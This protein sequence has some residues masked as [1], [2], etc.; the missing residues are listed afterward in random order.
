MIRIALSVSLLVTAVSTA[1]ADVSLTLP[2]KKLALSVAVQT[3]G[4]ATGLA[5]DLAVGVTDKL[6]VAIVHST[7]NATG[8]WSGSGTGSL[9]ITGD[10]CGDLYTGGALLAKLG[11][12]STPSFAFAAL[13]GVIHNI[14]AERSG[15]G[16][17]FEALYLAG[18]V[19]VHFKP[20]IYIGLDDRDAMA[21]NREYINAP[22]SLL[23][24]ATKTLQLGVQ[25]GVAGPAEGFGDAYRIPVGAMGNYAFGA[26]MSA[27]LAFNLDRVAGGGE[28]A[29]AT[30][31]R[32][33]TLTVG[34]VK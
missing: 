30:D 28:M 10:A 29:S 17:G 27:Q 24:P 33:V 20:T 11:L 18:P 21:P 6:T 23:V 12:A 1:S 14:A 4:D 8:F 16:A 9:C 15:L 25:S 19:G 2:Q 22:L 32:S 3:D 13:G 7:Q 26:G 5:P 31:A 34:W